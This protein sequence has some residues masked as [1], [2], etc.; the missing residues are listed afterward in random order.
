[1]PKSALQILIMLRAAGAGK[2]RVLEFDPRSPSE[3][4][5]RTPIEVESTP[6]SEQNWCTTSTISAQDSLSRIHVRIA[7]L[8]NR[9][10]RTRS[11]APP[12]K[13]RQKVCYE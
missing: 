11:R 10:R 5:E 7:A 8:R 12:M 1:M 6:K 4:V 13:T 2:F 9:W 3:N